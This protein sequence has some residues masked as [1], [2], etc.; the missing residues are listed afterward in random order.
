MGI[1]VSAKTVV[2]NDQINYLI[3]L[4]KFLQR[5]PTDCII[6]S[7]EEIIKEFRLTDQNDEGYKALRDRYNK[8]KKA[9]DLLVLSFYSFN[10]QIR[11]NNSQKFNASFGRNRSSYN[12]S[13]E[14]NLIE[15][16]EALKRKDIAFYSLDFSSVNLCD[17]GADDLVY[18]DPPYLISNGSYNDGNRG[19]KDWTEVE[20]RQLLELLDKL[21]NSKVKFALSNVLYHKGVSNN[22]LIEWGKKYNIHYLDKTYSNCSYNLKN[23][24]SETVEVVITNF[25]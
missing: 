3:E 12:S 16:S 7:I 11:F 5:T 24:D 6:K 1:N 23:R 2:C 14:N 17:L 18:C 4:Y 22:L 20:E 8:S 9:I 25:N 21:N 10:H 13:I 19:F 15:F